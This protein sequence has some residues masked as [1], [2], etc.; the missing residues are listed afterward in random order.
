MTSP[1]L[2]TRRLAGQVPRGRRRRHGPGPGHAGRL[3]RGADERPGLDAVQ[4]RLWRADRGA[5]EL[6]QRLSDPALGHPGRDRSSWPC[7]SCAGGV[8][9]PEFL[10]QPR[11]RAEQALVAVVCQA[12]VEGVSTRRVDDLVKAM[13][14]DGISKSEVSRLASR[15]RRRGERV[16]GASPGCRPLSLPVDR[17]RHPAGARGRPGGQCLGGDRHGRQRRGPPRDRRLRHRHHRGHRGV[18]GVLALARGP[19]HVRGG[20]R[21]LRRPRWAS[22]RPS[23]RCLPRPPG[24]GVAPTSWRISP[25]GCPR[26]TGP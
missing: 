13:G 15:A 26:P 9:S 23:P 14:I 10:L 5:G 8:Y 18:D 20:A 24:R 22:R 21:H 12:Y 1:P 25:R 6:S 7:R 19:G 17:R 2:S 16:P 4:R 11:R 3:R